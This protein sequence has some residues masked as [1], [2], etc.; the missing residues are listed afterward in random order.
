MNKK[1]KQKIKNIL[2][3][4]ETKDKPE[5]KNISFQPFLKITHTK[6]IVITHEPIKALTG[7]TQKEPTQTQTPS[8][9][10]KEAPSENVK[11][12]I[13]TPPGVHNE[14]GLDCSGQGECQPGIVPSDSDEMQNFLLRKRKAVN[15][16]TNTKKRTNF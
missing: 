13:N 6:T 15:K 4:E 5:Q 2:K 16:R 11:E 7:E 12:A 1:Q 8:E 10:V 9:N 14:I 3:N